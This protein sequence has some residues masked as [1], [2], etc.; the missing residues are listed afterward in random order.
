MAVPYSTGVAVGGSIGRLVAWL[1]VVL[2]M[3]VTAFT[4]VILT[5]DWNR[6]RPY[7]NGAVSEAIGRPFAIEGDLKVGWRQ[8]VSETGWRS[9][10]P[11]PHFSA[12]HVTIANP[13]WTKERHF[14]TFDEIDFQVKV[15]P[16]L[17][18]DIVIPTIRLTNPS[19]DLE[20]LADGRN[21]WTFP[22]SAM[23]RSGWRLRL[24]DV[25]L[26]TG[27]V[28]LSDEQNK[29][30]LRVVIDTLGHPIPIGEALQHQKEPHTES[31]VGNRTLALRRHQ[32]QPQYGIAWTLSGTYNRLPVSGSGKL[33]GVLALQDI[34][35]P[36]PV[37]ADVMAGD[38]HIALVGTLTGI[39][40]VVAVDLWLSLQ[41]TSLDHLSQLAGITLPVT[42]AFT[43]EGRLI[44]N[45]RKGQR[46]IRY[47]DFLGRIGGSDLS[48]TLVYTER[49]P[50]PLLEGTLVSNLLQFNDL[51][52][53]FGTDG[54]PGKTKHGDTSGSSSGKALLAEQIRTDRWKTMNADVKFT[55]RRIV[56]NS[57][58]PITDLTTHIVMTDGVLSIEPLKFTVAGGSVESGIQL[59]GNARPLKGRLS[60][61]ARHL[62][63]KQLFPSVK[64][65]QSAHGEINGDLGLSA[66]GDSLAALAR[67]S[68]GDV[69]LLMTDGTI[70]PQLVAAL[71]PRVATTLYRKLFNDRDVHIKC[72]AGDF[73]V[74]NGLVESRVSALDAQDAVID[75]GGKTNLQDQT[76]DLRARYSMGVSIFRLSSPLYVKGT[77]RNPQI[78]LDPTPLAMRGGAMVVLGLI[79]PFMALIPLIEPDTHGPLPCHQLAARIASR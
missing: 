69:K 64:T 65:M 18:H 72:A 32:G 76:M 23:R 31:M 57:G 35:R 30:E 47:E 49:E 55:G 14:A 21:D 52:S 9:W 73:A 24:Q 71:G 20:R 51:G 34:S 1:A 54:N 28:A 27:T 29:I 10:V 67:A 16:L 8:P 37:Q 53:L 62:K 38:S 12:R 17:A 15:L 75:V 11:W 33:G 4:L 39:G 50:R 40:H 78:T 5:F 68:N 3:L 42:P 26:N 74:T 48:G 19:F 61:K 13:D 41:C 79:N 58:P 77:F 25:Q 45:L 44:G 59:D 22:A 66:T 7:I 56:R 70:S 6:A 36:L 60:T 46:V 2:L 63:L 43:T